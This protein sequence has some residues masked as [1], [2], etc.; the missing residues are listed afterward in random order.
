VQSPSF[1]HLSVNLLEPLNHHFCLAGHV[2]SP[3]ANRL[4]ENAYSDTGS[5]FGAK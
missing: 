5:D 2:A 3:I 1:D 4:S